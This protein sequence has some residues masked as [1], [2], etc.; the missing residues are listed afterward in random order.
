MSRRS[1]P[2][3]AAVMAASAAIVFAAMSAAP[4]LAF[5]EAPL[6]PG[7]TRVPNVVGVSGKTAVAR[8]RAASFRVEVLP[9]VHNPR[10]GKRRV[11]VQSYPGGSVH[12]RGI[13]I[14]IATSAGPAPA[15]RWRTAQASVFGGPG[16]EQE[17]AGPYPDT[18]Y[19]NGHGPLYF[20]HKSL[21]FRTKVAFSY[22]GRTVVAVCADRGPYC[23][24]R[25][26]DLGANTARRLGFDLGA[27]RWAIVR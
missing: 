14:R 2:N 19:M 8:L 13:T 23:G 11:A 4:G 6:P 20:A 17:V 25:E 9:A 1:H 12:S 26:F 27:V 22:R 15:L 5:A 16:E 10:I 24:N 7:L 3:R 18:S 21:P